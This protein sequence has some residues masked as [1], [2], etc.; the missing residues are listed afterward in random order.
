MIKNLKMPY[1]FL[2]AIAVCLLGALMNNNMSTIKQS[3]ILGLCVGVPF[4]ILIQL[5]S[6]KTN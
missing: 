4:G 1:P 2:V 5:A 6:N 3:L